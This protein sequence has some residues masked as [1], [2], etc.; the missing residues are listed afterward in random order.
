[1]HSPP[2]ILDEIQNAPE[3]MPYIVAMLRMLH[4]SLRESSGRPFSPFPWEKSVEEE[5]V[6]FSSA[7][8]WNNI[9]M[10]GYP[11][12]QAEPG[13]D[14]RLWHSSYIQTYLERD[15]RTLRQVGDITMFQS[16]LRAIASRSGQLLNFA[17]V[18]RDLGVALNTVKQWLSVL[19]ATFQVIILRPGYKNPGKRLVKRPKVYF[20]D[21]GTLCPLVGLKDAPY[22]ADGPMG[23]GI[24]AIPFSRL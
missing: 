9:L 13:R 12:L 15:V 21:T 4:L 1:M 7:D 16:F 18:S 11:E 14:V 17:D 20:N 23:P 10:G 6:A 24:T 8:L 3:L 5:V 22:A 2:G 19:E